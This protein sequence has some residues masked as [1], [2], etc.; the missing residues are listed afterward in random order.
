MGNLTHLKE[1]ILADGNI[2]E[3]EVSNLRKTLFA[4][5]KIDAEEA[6][7]LFEL[8]DAA[9]NGTHHSSWGQLFVD[10]ICSFMLD[11]ENSPG[12]I[13]EQ[14]AKWLLNKIKSDG[15]LDDIEKTLLKELKI[16]S[17]IMPLNLMEFIE[18]SA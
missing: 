18:K 11:D 6:D 15:Q 3:T 12:E 16:K 5:N 17:S 1:S 13:D 7:F 8:K 9:V 14:E 10:A 4:D 2:D